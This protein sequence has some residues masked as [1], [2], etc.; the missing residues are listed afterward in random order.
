MRWWKIL[1][2]FPPK[3]LSGKMQALTIKLVRTIRST[4]GQFLALTAVVMVG[5][6]VYISMSTAF[7]N[8]SQ[9]KDTFYREHNFAD[10]NFHV[11]KAPEVVVKQIEA[12][13]GVLQATGRI[14]KELPVL[15]ENGQRASVRL[16]S[17]PLPMDKQVNQLHLVSGRMFEE[18]GSGI[19]VLVDPQYGKANN[20]KPGSQIQVIAEGKKTSLTVMGT[21][22][23]P[24]FIYTLKDSSSIYNDP[25]KFGIVM[26]AHREAQ[27]ILNIEGQ[28]NQVVVKLAP[29]LDEEKT[30]KQIEQ[31][32][33]PYGNIASYP[34]E[35][36]LSNATLTAEIDGLEISSRFMP[37]IF[38]LVAAAI[39]FILL[40]RLIKSQRTQIGIIKAL[41]YSNLRIIANYAGYAVAVSTTG[42]L[43]GLAAGIGMASIISTVYAMFFN[44]PQTIGGVNTTA[45]INSLLISNGVGLVSGVIASIQITGINPAAAMHPEPPKNYGR[46][47]FEQ[48]Q[49]LW[50]FL[51]TSWKMTLRSI[52]RNRTRFAVT[53]IGMSSAAAILVLSLGMNDSVDYMLERFFAQ[54]NRYDYLVQFSQPVKTN[55]ILYIERWEE[56]QIAEPVLEVPVEFFAGHGAETLSEENLITG[57]SEH[58]RLKGIFDEKGNPLPLPG[59][60]III[61]DRTAQKLHLK[62]G[63]RIRL[64]TKMALGASREAY[65]T[66][67]GINQQ[68]M[69][70]GGAFATLTTANN[71]LG[72][73]QVISGLMLKIVPGSERQLE[74]R[75]NEIPQV[76]SVTSRSQE[77]QNIMQLMD[78]MIYFIG[79]M[80]LFSVVLGLAIVYNSLIM[81]FNERKRELASL[82]VLG[83][84]QKEVSKLLFKETLVQAIVGI[85]LGL[86]GGTLMAKLY[87]KAMS[88][89]LFTMSLVVYPDSYLQAGFL[90]LAFVFVGYLFTARQTRQLD[91]VEVLKN[92]D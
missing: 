42:A 72:E 92:K 34:R 28:I 61:N 45:I 31:I 33:E 70:A 8:L 4:R 25:Q 87:I 39:Q 16:I 48:C 88:T 29:G 86:P 26:M 75:L 83:I 57:L 47:I 84:T 73:S 60:G 55:E 36:Q 1:I 18:T 64:E 79:I 52:S 54:D 35:D 19:S 32:L 91:L 41:G 50:N 9:S 77:E 12:L 53:V 30:A 27:Q 21:A 11:V 90:A 59:E 49:W 40:S 56:V 2:R 65:V 38:F 58:S 3:G 10:Y 22:I 81:G 63:D 5:V 69:M 85:A 37:M 24:E 82:R 66:V 7:Y 76:A 89:D 46:T 74:A 62:A 78:S 17:Y 13:P 43:L 80:V 67:A 23:S 20:L 68:M 71:L 15:K 6:T 14:V 44:L 51:H